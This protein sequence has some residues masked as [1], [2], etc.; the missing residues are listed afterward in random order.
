MFSPEPSGRTL[1]VGA[2][3]NVGAIAAGTAVYFAL[4]LGVFGKSGTW[5]FV[6]LFALGLAL[7]SA[8]IV[9]QVR[10]FR[11]GAARLTGVLTSLYLAVLFFAAVYFGLSAHWPGSVVQLRTKVD[12]LYFALS[13]TSTVGFGDVHAAGQQARAVVGVHLVFNL[14]F[15]GVAVHAVR[16]VRA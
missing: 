2:L 9:R 13:I 8:A 6:A 4:P 16:S 10:R 5:A 14:G 11:S 12:A 1:L 7:V 3:T 15:L